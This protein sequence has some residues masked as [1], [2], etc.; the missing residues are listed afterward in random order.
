M[1]THAHTHALNYSI[2]LELCLPLYTNSHTHTCVGT[3]HSYWPASSGA[4]ALPGYG[5]LAGGVAGV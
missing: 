4:G 2:A 1:H 3:A 5:A